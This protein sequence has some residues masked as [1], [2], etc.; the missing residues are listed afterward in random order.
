MQPNSCQGRVGQAGPSRVLGG[1]PGTED[2]GPQCVPLPYP[3]RAEGVRLGPSSPDHPSASPCVD[4]GR[5]K[6]KA[7]GDWR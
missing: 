2:L 6:A 4:L 1:L 5:H 3:N 7:S